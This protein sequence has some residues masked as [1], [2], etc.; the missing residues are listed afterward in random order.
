MPDPGIPQFPTKR[1][2]LHLN[3]ASSRATYG[4]AAAPSLEIAKEIALRSRWSFRSS[5]LILDAIRF[6]PAWADALGKAGFQNRKFALAIYLRAAIAPILAPRNGLRIGLLG[7]PDHVR[8]CDADDRLNVD[9]ER[10]IAIGLTA[11]D[12]D[13]IHVCGRGAS[14]QHQKCRYCPYSSHRIPQRNRPSGT[15]RTSRRLAAQDDAARCG[16]VQF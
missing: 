8:F 15:V 16:A 7:V 11:T 5:A 3:P 12:K 6:R 14:G 2:I 9:P 13:P 4:L 10:D 1:P